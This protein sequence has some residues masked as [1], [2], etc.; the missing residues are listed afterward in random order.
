MTALDRPNASTPKTV[1]G[2]A[3]FL[4]GLKL[5]GALPPLALEMIAD[6][7]TRTA[8][9]EAGLTVSA[10]E[11]QGAAD[12]FR[13][14][15][16][17]T[18]GDQARDWLRSS[19]MTVEDFETRL[20]GELLARKFK[21]HLAEG[22]LEGH[23]ARNRDRYARA[24]LS[25]ILVSSE[26]EARE[27]RSQLDTEGRDFAELAREHS[28]DQASRPV[29]GRLGTVSREHLP[30]SLAEAVFAARD[31]DVVGPLPTP[32]GFA[33]FRVEEH[34]APAL[35][36]PTREQI[37]EELYLAWLG[38]QVRGFHLETERPESA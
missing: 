24:R 11:L 18:R 13:R 5:R 19:G 1:L 32:R 12:L 10:D 3:E 23:F 30:A 35:D 21:D 26:G 4:G 8:A 37:R 6:K 9:A 2:L 15:H 28:L 33:L 31:G 20:E 38:E 29:G 25:R 14:R 17:L 34:V 16:G 27:V 7:I 36:D 22:R